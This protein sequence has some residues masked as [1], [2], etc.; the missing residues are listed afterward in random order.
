[1][2]P[3]LQIRDFIAEEGYPAKLDDDG[4][5]AFKS[6]GIKFFVSVE[7]DPQLYT[8]MRSFWS[9]GDIPNPEERANHVNCKLKAV[10]CCVFPE[11]DTVV[12]GIEQHC[13]VA[14]F[15]ISFARSLAIL[16]AG[17]REF[18]EA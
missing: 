4:D 18:F 11:S 13:T 10:K 2:D 9:I 15:T 5:I 1:M 12:V 14:S 6:E 8:V 16:H 3:V 17:I 7:T